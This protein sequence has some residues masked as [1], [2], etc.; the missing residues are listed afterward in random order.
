MKALLEKDKKRRTSFANKEVQRLIL[1]Y[2]I[3]N[4]K[5]P[6]SQRLLLTLRLQEISR[7]SSL[8]RLKNRCI[9]TNR[10]KGVY[11][12]FRLSRI[13]LREML[14]NGLIPGYKKAV[15]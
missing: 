8:V 6:A 5:L 11:R 10:S 15:W 3:R 1:L 13:R 4:Q 14:A 12:E 2:L 9:L 7:D